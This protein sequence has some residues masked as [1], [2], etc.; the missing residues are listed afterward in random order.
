MQN[1]EE[2]GEAEE[3]TDTADTELQPDRRST[4]A[5]RL[6]AMSAR[7]SEA[8]RT[9]ESEPAATRSRLCAAILSL[10]RR[11]QAGLRRLFRRNNLHD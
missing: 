3:D 11:L 6:T 1:D 4:V 10:F 8:I 9:D 5:R 7:F 2:E